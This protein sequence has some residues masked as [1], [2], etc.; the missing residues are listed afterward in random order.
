M[1]TQ[2]NSEILDRVPPSDP[3]AESSLLGSILLDPRKIDDV[4]PVL[5][6]V[7]FYS[8]VNQRLYE[9]VVAIH[10]AEGKC[11]STMLVDYLRK[12]GDLEAV[13]GLAYLAEVV[14]SVPVAAHAVHYARIIRQK[15]QRRMLVRAG[16]DLV[17]AAWD[18]TQTPAEALSAAETIMAGIQ[19]GNYDAEPVTMFDAVA[20]AVV[21]IE[22][23]HSGRTSP[24]FMVGMPAYDTEVGGVF[25]RELTIIA[26][27]PSQG[28]SSM[29]L[30]WAA[31][32]ASQGKRVYFASLEMS[33]SELATK[34]LCSESGVSSHRV[35]TAR[36]TDSDV[37]NINEAAPGVASKHLLIH[38][39]PVLTPLDI[40][41][42]ARKLNSQV[43]FVDYLQYVTPPDQTKQRYLQIADIARGLK[44]MAKDLD[45]PVVACAQVG[46][47]TD[48]TKESR[49]RLSSL[50]ESGDIENAAD[51]VGILWRPTDGISS[52]NE[53]WDAELDI[54][55]NRNGP[56]TRIRLN[57]NASRTLFDCHD[58][59]QPVD[60]GLESANT[61]DGF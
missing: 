22:S 34:R 39:S 27:R 28:K 16:T 36:L 8:P 5:D 46:R 41:R 20:D 14:K 52:G 42:A 2:P 32:I 55:K 31:Y 38:D 9:H 15:A 19:T 12:V 58:Y 21:E 43:I 56:T 57:W 4:G 11:D 3:A 23:I 24:G 45:V 60:F 26:A 6:P 7:D 33:R 59:S 53:Q 18:D 29:A 47:P 13:G 37:A 30:Q 48:K 61:P 50:R 1:E 10:D 35:R 44:S 51:V 17:Q 54:A 40:Q 49:P 25:P